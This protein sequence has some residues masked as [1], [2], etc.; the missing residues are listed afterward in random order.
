MQSDKK[1]LSIKEKAVEEFKVF[2][3]S[4]VGIGKDEILARTLM[5]VVTF[6]PFFC[7][8]ETNRALGPGKLFA[9]FFQRRAQ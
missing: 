1:A 4:F 6:I 5:V 8:W 7:F 3:Q 2:W 9:L